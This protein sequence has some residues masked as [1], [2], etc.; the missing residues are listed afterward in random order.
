MVGYPSNS[1]ASCYADRANG[2]LMYQ[3][4]HLNVWSSR[5]GQLVRTHWIVLDCIV[6]SF[7]NIPPPLAVTGRQNI[8]LVQLVRCNVS[9]RPLGLQCTECSPLKISCRP[10]RFP[11]RIY[12]LVCLRTLW[13]L[14]GFFTR[15]GFFWHCLGIGFFY[16]NLG[17]FPFYSFQIFWNRKWPES[18]WQ[19]LEFAVVVK[20]NFLTHGFLFAF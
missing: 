8:P 17:F 9:S 20:I 11:Y 1:W 12:Y 16:G 14:L 13:P 2:T 7:V 5:C 4:L 18:W 19:R 3:Y 15:S 6:C 10:Y